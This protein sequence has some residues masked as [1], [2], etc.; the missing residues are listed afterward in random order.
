[1]D[2]LREDLEEQ[3]SSSIQ[4]FQVSKIVSPEERYG[5]ARL[6]TATMAQSDLQKYYQALEKAIMK[7]LC[8]K[9]GEIS[10]DDALLKFDEIRLYS[11]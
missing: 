10:N 6:E 2:H 9:V 5:S 1:M 11:A 3:F 4:R 7:S 8:A